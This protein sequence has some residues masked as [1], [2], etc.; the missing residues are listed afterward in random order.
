ME[1]MRKPSSQ[2]WPRRVVCWRSVG[3]FSAAVVTLLPL[4]ERIQVVRTLIIPDPDTNTTTTCSL[5]VN[6]PHP[7]PQDPTFLVFDAARHQRNTAIQTQA[8]AALRTVQDKNN[9]KAARKLFRQIRR[10]LRQLRAAQVTHN[11]ADNTP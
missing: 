4:R 9:N 6:G 11:N 1:A 5:I 7:D 8:L 2:N 3:A 10:L